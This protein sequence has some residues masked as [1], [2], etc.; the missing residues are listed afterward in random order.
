[1]INNEQI[2]NASLI[3]WVC[4]GTLDISWYGFGSHLFSTFDSLYGTSNGQ[5]V[6]DSLFIARFLLQY[7]PAVSTLMWWCN[8]ITQSCTLSNLCPVT[9]F[10]QNR[11]NDNH[12]WN[13]VWLILLSGHKVKKYF[14]KIPFSVINRE[15]K[16]SQQF[17]CRFAG[18]PNTCG[19][20]STF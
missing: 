11:I 10:N 13:W 6:H 16:V 8:M 9:I 12:F 15:L 4:K 19:N 1:M 14:C 3:E 7:L 17:K 5:L 18:L 2:Q 20:Y